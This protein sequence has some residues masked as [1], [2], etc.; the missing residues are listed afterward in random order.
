M[1]TEIEVPTEV[2]DLESIPAANEP[3]EPENPSQPY[4]PIG[5]E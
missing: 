5:P 4:E 2:P 1:E 3:S